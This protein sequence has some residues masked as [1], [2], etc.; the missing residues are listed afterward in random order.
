MR[1]DSLIEAYE[2]LYDAFGP[3][4]WWPGDTPFEII[5]G[6]I[7]TQN[8]NWKNVEKAIANL[9]RNGLLSARR[10]LETHPAT[11]ANLIRPA[12]YFR[13]KTK[14]LRNFLNFFCNG[15]GGKISALGLK[16]LPDLRAQLLSVNGI[17]PETAD[18]ILLYALDK[19]VFVVDAYTKRIFSRHNMV[20][21]ETNYDEIQSLFMDNL[22][23]KAKLFNEYHALIVRCGKD[24]CLTKKPRC[25][26]CPLNGWN[27]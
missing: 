21:E 27:I 2:R 22:P 6:A 8:T 1:K 25:S 20:P 26:E 14:R 4:H 18:S 19:P 13:I 24:C 15:F 10:L 23:H 11:L 16:E 3:Q 7:L 9:K 12:G 5:V 17:G